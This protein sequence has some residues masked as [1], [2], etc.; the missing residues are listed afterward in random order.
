MAKPPLHNVAT[1]NP[2]PIGTITPAIVIITAGPPT[3][4]ICF[5]SVSK[6]AEKRIKIAPILDK[7][8]KPSWVV[9]FNIS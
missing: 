2:N 7:N 8:P 3:D 6:P 1:K 9:S 4:L 5:K